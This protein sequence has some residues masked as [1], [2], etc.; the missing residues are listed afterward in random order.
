MPVGVVVVVVVVEVGATVVV[1]TAPLAA[2]EDTTGVSN[3]PTTTAVMGTRQP[4]RGRAP[5]S[6]RIVLTG[7]VPPLKAVCTPPSTPQPSEACRE[8]RALEN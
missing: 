8:S 1:V 2:T 3:S 6:R 5:D 7:N 4:R